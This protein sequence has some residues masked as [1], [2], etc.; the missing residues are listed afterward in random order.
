[1]VNGLNLLF[2]FL[3]SFAFIVLAAAGLAIIFGI[4]GVINLAH[5]EF[6]MVG[7]Y[8]TTLANIRAG[9]PL[10]AAMLVG[11]LVTAGFGLVVER[12]VISGTVPNALSQRFLGR[13]VIE[14][15]YDRLADS[16]VATW[17]LSLIM[18]QGVRITLGNSLDQ[19]GT[20]LGNIAYSGF[21]YS[22]YR[23]MLA[24]VALGVLALTYY[25]FTR[26][27]YGMRA[28]AT[29][30][31]EDTARALGVDTERT[32]MTTFAIGSG[33]AGLTGALYAPTITMVP[34]L[35]SSFLVEAFVAVVVGGPSVVLGT[36]LAGGLL[37]AINATVSNVLGT[38][39]GRIALLV[40]AIVMIR[41]LPDGITGF[42]ETLRERRQ[43]GA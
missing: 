6:I 25:V 9:L 31:D 19:I 40:T 37:G 41:F 32:Y 3:D 14:P 23:V 17:G 43:E 34:G 21:S 7:A 42:V 8:A 13:K 2:Q 35:G 38:F 24:A 20:P 26:T 30:Q 11:V 12:V 10:P 1:M 36:T 16:M 39:F 33:L 22:T 27:E 29:I 4:M 18:V 5:G 15:L 28:R